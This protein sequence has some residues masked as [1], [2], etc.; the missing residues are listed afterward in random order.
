[1]VEGAEILAQ[2]IP[3][4]AGMMGEEARM[5]RGEATIRALRISRCWYSLVTMTKRVY[6]ARTCRVS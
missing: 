4:K 1:V 6:E 5:A 2:W 3:A